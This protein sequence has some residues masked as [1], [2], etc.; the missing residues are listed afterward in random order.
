[1]DQKLI[2]AAFSDRSPAKDDRIPPL[3][4]DTLR[5]SCTACKATSKILGTRTVWRL[6]IASTIISA[7]A[8]TTVFASVQTNPATWSKYLV[9]A[10]V[11]LAAVLTGVQTWYGRQ[12]DSLK[13]TR[14]QLHVLHQDIETAVFNFQKGA[15]LSADFARDVANRYTNIDIDSI[16]TAGTPWD[17]GR[18]E[19]VEALWTDF[20]LRSKMPS[21]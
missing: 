1:M 20:G 16:P 4:L 12:R 11:V 2:T 15:A 13:E 19:V 21:F 18:R 3:I 17:K 9:A 10:S 14:N 8:A 7:A 6:G 5:D